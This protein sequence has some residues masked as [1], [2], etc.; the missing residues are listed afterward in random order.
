MGCP[1]CGNAEFDND[2]TTGQ[3]FCEK[4]SRIIDEYNP[5]CPDCESFQ[6]VNDHERGE[7]FCR[8]CGLIIAENIID[9]GPEWRGYDEDLKKRCRIGPPPDFTIA[10]KEIGTST[11]W[12]DRDYRGKYFKPEE[13][14]LLRRLKIQQRRA[15]FT[16]REKYLA[17]ALVKIG[18]IVSVLKLP[19]DLQK[20]AAIIYRKA[21]KQNL[22]RGRSIEAIAAT[23]VYW[24]CKDHGVPRTFEEISK[25]SGVSKKE[26]ARTSKIISRGLKLEFIIVLPENYVPRFCSELNLNNETKLEAMDLL[27]KLEKKKSIPSGMS[28]IGFVASI[29]YMAS[30]ITGDWRKQKDIAAVTGVTVVTIRKRYKQ[31]VKELGIKL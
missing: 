11:N 30:I 24:A 28:I 7:L 14:T 20:R 15:Q 25:A 13:R 21:K 10:D 9:L 29:I 23:A 3:I 2:P 16:S 26:I 5:A 18:T 1:K 19:K 12:L 17:I 8:D 22:I 6:L 27:Q 4:C 31:I